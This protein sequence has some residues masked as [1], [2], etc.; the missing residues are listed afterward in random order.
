[1]RFLRVALPVLVASGLSVP[2]PARQITNTPAQQTPVFRSAVDLVAVDV[3]VVNRD[4]D[5]IDTLGIDDFRVY[6]NG[7]PR[8][9]VS[10]EFIRKPPLPPPDAG[11]PERPVRT[12]G[13]VAPGARVFILAVDSNSL[14]PHAL[15]AAVRAA[16]TFLRQLD[17]DDLVALYAYPFERPLLSL[18]HDRYA[19]SRAL[20]RIIGNYVPFEGVFHMS[21]S[22][23]LDIAANDG[24]AFN[25]VFARECAAGNSDTVGSRADPT[26]GAGVRMEAH[27][28][29]A[30]FDTSGMTSLR[31]VSLLLDTLALLPGRK[32]VVLVSG[33]MP[34]SDR[35]GGRPSLVESMATLGGEAG[36][37]NA[38]LYVL[39]LDNAFFD[40]MSVAEQPLRDPGSRFESSMRD[41][42]LS[43]LGLNRLAG[44]VGGTLLSD[45]T[46]SGERALG[47]VLRESSAY[48][49]LGAEPAPQDRDGK[50][51]FLRVEV[52]KRG[53]TVRSRT[54]VV[55][56]KPGT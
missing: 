35:V 52:G 13:V 45:P 26:C 1:M 27:A 55:I 48:Y 7:H 10:V 30:Y 47:R 24:D 3:Q 28:Y 4:G 49:L 14:A 42:H 38:S 20:D 19:V 23:A 39:H 8:R 36:R 16:Q 50:L 40:P 11:G 51:H 41:A 22:E 56:P 15:K 2:L 6:F 21:V 31:G 34:A 43:A 46:G 37:A 25:R 9:V 54:Q 18:T 29:A 17:P 5:P 12:P 33:G 44:K 32:T 53:M